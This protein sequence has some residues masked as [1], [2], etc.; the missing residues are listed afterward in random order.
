MGKLARCIVC[1]EANW[2]KLFNASEH[3]QTKKHIQSKNRTL[4]K[5]K[6]IPAIEARPTIAGFTDDAE[7]ADLG[8]SHWICNDVEDGTRHQFVN[9]E[10]NN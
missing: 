3:A 4:S 8:G 9:L 2:T 7:P 10:N 1:E 6:S 5:L